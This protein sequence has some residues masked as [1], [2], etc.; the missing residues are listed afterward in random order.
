MHNGADG[1]ED[2]PGKEAN[3]RD[4]VYGSLIRIY[5]LFDW[6]L[7]GLI[8]SNKTTFSF[9]NKEQ[10]ENFISFLN[11]HKTEYATLAKLEEK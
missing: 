6:I 3:A 10:C 2:N 9:E 5:N 4:S 7:Y 8:L 11:E 1:A